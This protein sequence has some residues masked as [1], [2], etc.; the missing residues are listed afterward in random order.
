MKVVRMVD[1]Y[2]LILLALNILLARFLPPR[3]EEILAR[4]TGDI[5]Y[6]V[7]RRRRQLIA[8][9]LSIVLGNDIAPHKLEAITREVFRNRWME[10]LSYLA[11]HNKNLTQSVNFLGLEHLQ[12]ALAKGKG[13]ILWETPF[14]KRLLANAVLAKKGFPLCQLHASDHGASSHSWLGRKVVFKLRRKMEANLFSEIVDIQDDSLAYLRLVIHRLGQNGIVCV[15]GLGDRG[16]KFV[17]VRFMGAEN[18]IATGVV[19]LARMTGASIIPMFCFRD[20][21]GTDQLVLEKPISVEAGRDRDEAVAQSIKTYASLLE[22]Y[23]RR[24][25]AQWHQWRYRWPDFPSL[26]IPKHSRLRHLKV[27][28]PR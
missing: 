27:A 25:P 22:S 12:D 14:G 23:I 10:G 6:L 3:T 1:I 21:N 28:K 5:T 7:R 18:E 13:V 2:D 16:H 26:G 15:A 17:P 9:R 20:D 8:D 19:S 11:V 4:V 24:Y